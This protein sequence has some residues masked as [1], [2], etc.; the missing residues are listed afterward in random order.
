[1]IQRIK[2]LFRPLLQSCQYDA[3]A[4]ILGYVAAYELTVHTDRLSLYIEC[5]RLNF[6]HILEAALHQVDSRTIL[7]FYYAPAEKVIGVK[8]RCLVLSSRNN[9]LHSSLA[10]AVLVFVFVKEKILF[11]RII[12]PYLLY[13]L[14]SLPIIFQVIQVFNHLKR[15]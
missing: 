15:C 7:I 14:V 10:C 13:T 11:T 1:M 5:D 8:T 3:I 4:G 6:G 9:Y 2:V 12:G